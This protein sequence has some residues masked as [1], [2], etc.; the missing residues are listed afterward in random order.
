[1]L[2]APGAGGPAPVAGVW[3]R[4]PRRPPRPHRRRGTRAAT[5]ALAT[6]LLAGACSA[7]AA[8]EGE[9]AAPRIEVPTPEPDDPRP[10][11][12]D[13]DLEGVEVWVGS[14]E[15]PLHELLGHLAA[16]TLVAAGADVRHD[17]GLGDEVLAREALL[18][19][20]STFAW[21]PMGVA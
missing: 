14:Q 17:I 10:I 15:G 6:V 1:M 20:G 8:G 11:E 3:W 16:E 5:V 12:V 21:Q 18:S 7:E 19:G 13:P 4:C 9:E 2:A